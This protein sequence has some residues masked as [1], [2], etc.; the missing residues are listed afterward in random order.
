[1]EW[2]S[3]KVLR[4]AYE[5]VTLTEDDKAAFKRLL[6]DLEVERKKKIIGYSGRTRFKAQHGESRS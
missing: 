2:V 5:A 3:R 1:M 4:L 6:G